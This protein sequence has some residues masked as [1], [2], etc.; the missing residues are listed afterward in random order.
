M[1]IQRESKITNKKTSGLILTLVAIL[2][3]LFHFI[4]I[5]SLLT[6]ETNIIVTSILL[7]LCWIICYY[8]A[9]SWMDILFLI[10]N[11]GVLIINVIINGS[12]GCV[13]TSFNIILFLMILRR[14]T[15]SLRQV[16]MLRGAV[17]L[18]FAVL[19][20]SFEYNWG[21]GAL[22]V[23][24]GGNWI[25]PNTFGLMWLA[26][27]FYLITYIDATNNSKIAKTF[28]YTIVTIVSMTFIILS[29][30]RSVFFAV[31]F[32]V[33]LIMIKKINYKRTAIFLLLVGLI[34]PVVYTMLSEVWPDATFMG[35]NLFS[36]R[37]FVWKNTWEYIK[38]SPVIGTGT[39]NILNIVDDISLS[40]AHNTYLA[41][42][43]M[44]GVFSLISVIVYVVKHMKDKKISPNNIVSHKA[45]LACMVVFVFE[46]VLNDNNYNFLFMLLLMTVENAGNP[47][48][49][50]EKRYDT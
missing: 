34:F 18:L 1:N 47:A 10:V 33:V 35:K 17:I 41:F 42:W 6:S 26:L 3:F 15:F 5:N 36:G 21:Y 49:A 43:R 32:F 2:P 48:I 45:F 38:L 12:L 22:R 28:L 50:K 7:T 24:N 19:F 25:N 37:E 30:C 40:S 39:R 31:L 4:G 13:L 44:T 9:V 14:T 16:Q 20:L 27:F 23:Y 29:G 46:T 11:L 8:N